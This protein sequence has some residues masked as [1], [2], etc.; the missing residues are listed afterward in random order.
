MPRRLTVSYIFVRTV[1]NK[2]GK[3]GSVGMKRISWW[4]ECFEM[5]RQRQQVVGGGGKWWLGLCR[6]IRV[7]INRVC[8]RL[9]MGAF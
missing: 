1:E 5:G 6:N 2:L 4:P 8:R 9:M 3:W 7:R